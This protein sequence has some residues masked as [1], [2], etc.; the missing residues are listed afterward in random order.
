M[1]SNPAEGMDVCV[2]CGKKRQKCK[3]QDSQD[4]DT[5]TDKVQSAREYKKS[6]WGENSL[7]VQTEPM[8]VPASFPYVMLFHVLPL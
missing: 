7:A 2:V 5:S 8:A 3:M 4:K 6:R 1:G